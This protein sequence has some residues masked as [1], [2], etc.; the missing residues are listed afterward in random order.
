MF[1]KAPMR[2]SHQPRLTLVLGGARSGKSRHAEA[3][4]MRQ[5][6][7]WVYVATADGLDEEMR[8]RIRHHRARRSEGWVTVEAPIDLVGAL[9]GHGGAV[10]VDCLTLWL[11]NVILA[12]KDVTSEE[13]RL[14]A[15]L[16]KS[17]STIVAVSNEVGLG[18]VPD[19]RLARDFRD[20]QGRLNQRVAEIA[21]RVVFM[22]AGLPM[23]L[24]PEAQGP[25]TDVR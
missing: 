8:E 4:V 17:S 16:Q 10:L 22:A 3:C 24:K 2:P 7:P 21:D 1:S 25:Y 19:N 18:V 20:A 14:V 12:G 9:E 11:S 15:A 5:P 13:A 6:A 23:V